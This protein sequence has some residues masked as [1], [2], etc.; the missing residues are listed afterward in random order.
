MV[1]LPAYD[2]EVG[3]LHDHAPMMMLLGEGILRLEMATGS[4]RFTISGGFVQVLENKV[5]I[6]SEEARE[7]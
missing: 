4:R 1:V 6:L 7:A 5:S 2:G 3:I